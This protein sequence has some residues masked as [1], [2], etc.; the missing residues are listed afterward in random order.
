MSEE[1]NELLE[2]LR[3]EENIINEA[4]DEYSKKF[5]EFVKFANSGECRVQGEDEDGEE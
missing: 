2:K 5:Y 1:Q 4:N 3:E